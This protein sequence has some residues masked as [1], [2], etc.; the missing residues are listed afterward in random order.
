MAFEVHLQGRAR[1]AAGARKRWKVAGRS[2][3]A[4]KAISATAPQDRRRPSMA[5]VHPSTTQIGPSQA[6]D[7]DVPPSTDGPIAPP[8]PKPP[9]P[10]AVPPRTRPWRAANIRSDSVHR[11]RSGTAS[12]TSKARSCKLIPK[13]RFT[14]QKH[15]LQDCSASITNSKRT[16]HGTDT[17][18]ARHR[19]APSTRHARWHMAKLC[20]PM[21]PNRCY[22]MS[23]VHTNYGRGYSDIEIGLHF[24][25]HLRWMSQK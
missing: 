23:P 3:L 5:P 13:R 17:S 18:D 22:P 12:A 7:L 1:S 11:A 2:Q 25:Q 4:F 16:V 10:S 21:S 6:S 20:T 9:S 19:T 8:E 24:W 14:T 15:S